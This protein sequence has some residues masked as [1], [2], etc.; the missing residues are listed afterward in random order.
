MDPDAPASALLSSDELYADPPPYYEYIVSDYRE[1]YERAEEELREATERL[2]EA[3]GAL[4]RDAAPDEDI[5]AAR[6]KLEQADRALH[7]VR[8]DLDELDG[9]WGELYDMYAAAPMSDWRP[10]G[11]VVAR[12]EEPGAPA[13]ATASAAAMPRD[14]NII[15]SDEFY[16]R[17]LAYGRPRSR[18]PASAASSRGSSTAARAESTA[19]RAGRAG[20]RKGSTATRADRTSAREGSTATRAAA[21]PARAGIP[22]LDARRLLQVSDETREIPK[23]FKGTFRADSFRPERERKAAAEAETIREYTGKWKEAYSAW[24]AARGLAP[25]TGKLAGRDIWR[26]LD[27]PEE[28]SETD[29]EEDEEFGG[30][31][32]GAATA[33]PSVDTDKAESDAVFYIDKLLKYYESQ[34][35]DEE[36]S[37]EQLVSEHNEY[38]RLKEARETLR[39]AALGKEAEQ[40]SRQRELE[41]KRAKKEETRAKPIA[42]FEEYLSDPSPAA[43][44][45][46]FFAKKRI[47]Q[48]TPQ[49]AEREAKAALKEKL[50]GEL[51]Q[52]ATLAPGTAE[53]RRDAI[54]GLEHEIAS[55]DNEISRARE[56]VRE[57]YGK[58]KNSVTASNDRI[59][60][61]PSA[62]GAP[63]RAPNGAEG[64]PARPP[65]GA[66][67]AGARPPDANGLSENPNDASR[68]APGRGRRAEPPN[69]NSGAASSDGARETAAE[70]MDSFGNEELSGSLE[71]QQDT[72]A[73]AAGQ[74]AQQHAREV[75]AARTGVS[76]AADALADSLEAFIRYSQASELKGPGGATYIGPAS[77]GSVV[78]SYAGVALSGEREKTRAVARGP[79]LT[80]PPVARFFSPPRDVAARLGG[81]ARRGSAQPSP[82]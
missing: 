78:V 9:E 27:A 49:I 59:K 77:R 28:E 18:A 23:I 46:L 47:A 44:P 62:E 33:A 4:A 6:E 53:K 52:N 61:L 71:P 64:A 51:R 54:V 5:G 60:A 70:Q 63:A 72:E 68:E 17:P 22:R 43:F 11:G 26:D 30:E 58:Y 82:F 15:S 41:R 66:E 37:N 8:T 14:A 57:Q 21:L 29:L 2:E 32:A 56:Y 73:P 19:T 65:N 80:S 7:A 75:A 12:A 38:R 79:C 76:Q 1:R 10:G 31:G 39:I 69:M 45:F 3:S 48:I 35:E 24:R 40:Y 55:I 81:P 25:Y 74:S 34:P 13:Y 42:S 20:E 67:G 16:D 50:E 36:K